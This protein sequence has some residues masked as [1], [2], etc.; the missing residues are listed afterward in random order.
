MNLMLNRL[1]PN[2][3][4]PIESRRRAAG[5]VVRIAYAVIV[6]GVIGFFVVYFGLP[7]VVLG[8]PG[9]VSAPR[10]VVSAPY[11]VLVTRMNVM[12]GATVA[13]GEELGL[14][15]APQIDT[16]VASYMQSLAEITG[17]RAE[18]RVKARVAEE[19]LEAARAYLSTTEEAV[20][21]VQNS[22]GATVT[23]R[24]D[25]FREHAAAR[26]AVISHEAEA[27]EG[28]VQLAA[29]DEFAKQLGDHLQQVERDFAGGRL[30]APIA[31]VVSTEVAH[32]GQSLPAGGTIAE[33]LDPTDIFV[34]W[35]I[36]NARLID[37]KV[38]N[39]VFVLFGNRRIR[40]R[41]EQILPVSG[42][43]AGTQS[44]MRE[45]AYTQM[46]RIRFDPAA[47]PPALSSTVRVHMHYSAIS[48]WISDWVIRV[49]GV[50]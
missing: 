4:D 17:R 44:M 9:T 11:T 2:L 21:R 28:A 35:Y 46:A 25:I 41:I 37:P 45:R 16:L 22:P 3:P 10:Y 18:L 38:G 8:G 13:N 48:M 36:P 1:D 32:V 42:V 14:V 23:F 50:E 5:R 31:G 47:Q 39:E 27:A 43:F 6:F 49:L 30:L 26:K 34:D 12:P 20:G 24:V 40:G 19:S 15:R 29:L 7:F 33:I